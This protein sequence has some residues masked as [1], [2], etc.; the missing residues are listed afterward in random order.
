MKEFIMSVSLS[1]PE[2]VPQPRRGLR[3]ASQRAVPRG[4]LL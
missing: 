2:P 3:H 4:H 1:R